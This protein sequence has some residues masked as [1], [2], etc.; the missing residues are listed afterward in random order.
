MWSWKL[1]YEDETISLSCDIDNVVDSE[2]LEE[3]LFAP[4]DEGRPIPEKIAVWASI[5]I[6]DREILTKYVTQRE[7]AGLSV[8]G[9][10]NLSF[11]LS[12]IQ[13]DAQGKRYRVIPVVDIDEKDQQ[14]GTSSLL[15]ETK[16]VMVNGIENDWSNIDTP[17]TNR[18]IQSLFAFFYRPA[19]QR[20]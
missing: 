18:A 16:G 15:D 19:S 14:L 20:D 11:T 2:E 3:G 12:L 4:V 5:A 1:I 13:L 7:Q 10:E 8:E 9:Y 17:T 6:K